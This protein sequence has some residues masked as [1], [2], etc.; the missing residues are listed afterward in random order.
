MNEFKKLE[1]DIA[2]VYRNPMLKDGLQ[3]SLN[4]KLNML[5]CSVIHTEPQSAGKSS[6]SVIMKLDVS[7]LEK[8]TRLQRQIQFDI[9]ELKELGYEF[10]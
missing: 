4:N 7:K 1:L 9:D 6:V 3:A 5:K 8:V 2:K 10:I